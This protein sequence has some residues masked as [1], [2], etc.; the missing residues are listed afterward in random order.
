MGSSLKQRQDET[1]KGSGTVFKA[2]SRKGR[3]AVFIAMAELNMRKQ[4][5]SFLIFEFCKITLI[6]KIF[7]MGRNCIFFKMQMQAML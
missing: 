7:G 2:K 4:N 6:C 1:S 3:E 5:G